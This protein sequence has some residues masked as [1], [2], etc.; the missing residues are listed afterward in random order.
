MKIK[1]KRREQ[2]KEMKISS[3]LLPNG[4]KFKRQKRVFL[5]LAEAYLYLEPLYVHIVRVNEKWCLVYE[6]CI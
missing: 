3:S 4:Y 6:I 5:V 2:K 1:T